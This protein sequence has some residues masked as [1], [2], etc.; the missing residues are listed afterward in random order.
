ML[1]DYSIGC[2]R[3]HSLGTAAKT[4]IMGE[5]LLVFTGL[6]FGAH[7]LFMR[8]PLEKYMRHGRKM[9]MNTSMIC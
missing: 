7:V 4:K 1:N 3:A 8:L 2:T 6:W 9:I 5:L